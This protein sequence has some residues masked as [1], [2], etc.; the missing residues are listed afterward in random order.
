MWVGN[1]STMDGEF[2]N[3]TTRDSI[4]VG[5]YGTD[6]YDVMFNDGTVQTYPTAMRAFAVLNSTGRAP[7]LL[8]GK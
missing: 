2:V 7:E 3:R 4:A 1:K 5:A 8:T 6:G